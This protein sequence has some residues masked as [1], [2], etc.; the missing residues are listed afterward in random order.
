[1][2]VE[3]QVQDRSIPRDIAAAFDTGLLTQAQ[4]RTLIKI[5]ALRIGLSLD[6]ALGLARRGEL[7]G[8][9]LAVGLDFLIGL[10][11]D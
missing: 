11:D 8:P 9:A 2:A 4:L 6:E 3:K 10:L 5:E 7:P 1:M